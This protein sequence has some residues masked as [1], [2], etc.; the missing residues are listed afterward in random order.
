MPS[1]DP[2][3]ANSNGFFKDPVTK[4]DLTGNEER[5]IACTIDNTGKLIWPQVKFSD[6]SVGKIVYKLWTPAEKAIYKLYREQG[7][8]HSRPIQTKQPVPHETSNVSPLKTTFS[9][10]SSDS[11]ATPNLL[12][13]IRNC[14][15]HLGVWFLHGIIHD[16]LSIKGDKYYTVIARS[17]IPKEDRERLHII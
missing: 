8:Q 9:V 10:P 16:L 14:D 11:I 13:Y 4:K 1:F 17:L 2:T 7:K 5:V 6:G 3:V 12:A 15:Q